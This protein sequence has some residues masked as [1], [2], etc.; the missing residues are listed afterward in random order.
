MSKHSIQAIS[1]ETYPKLFVVGCPRSGTSWVKSL[2]G[3][4]PD[5]VSVPT[6]TQAY[7]LIYEP[8]LRLPKQPLQERLKGWKGILRRY[9]PKPLLLS[10]DTQDIWQGILSNY[11]ILNKPDSYGLHGLASREAFKGLLQQA[12]VSP[13][14]RLKQAENLIAGL[15]DHFYQQQGY[16]GMSLLEKTPMHLRYVEQILKRFPEARVIEVIRDGRDVCVSYNALAKTQ[17]WARIGSAGAIR[18]WRQ[19][20]KMGEAYRARPDLAARISTVRY[21]QLQ[22]DTAGQLAQ[23]FDFAGLRWHHR[24]IEHIVQ[25]NDIRRI[26]YRGEGKPHRQGRTSDWQQTLSK[27]DQ[28]LCETVAGEQLAQLGYTAAA[29]P[30][31]TT[32]GTTSFDTQS[33]T[34]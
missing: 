10:F 5:V 14:D 33:P 24:Q 16:P 3:G 4:H 11:D 1:G 12:Q 15:L 17:T 26:R 21:E 25:A 13:G 8:F 22:A 18:Q 6:E 34:P 23:L 30:A 27:A 9:G 28:Q 32:N 29:A 31:I 19:C 20:I 2:V 7:R